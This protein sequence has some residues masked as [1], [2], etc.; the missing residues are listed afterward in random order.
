M[1]VNSNDAISTGL[2]A[3]LKRTL[4]MIAMF[5][6]FA[7]G[8][9]VFLSLPRT[10]MLSKVICWLFHLIQRTSSHR[11]HVLHGPSKDLSHQH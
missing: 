4:E 10:A 6:M 11:L 3:M 2:W 1:P 5:K 7:H 9:S 8:P